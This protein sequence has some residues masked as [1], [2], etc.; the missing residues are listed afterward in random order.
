MQAYWIRPRDGGLVAFAALVETYAEPGGSEMD[1][2]AIVTASANADIAHIHERMPVVI[3]PRDFSRWLDCRTQE[4]RHVADLMRPAGPGL[5]EAVPVSGLVN[6]V[7]NTGPE[8]QEMALPEGPK[9]Q[10]PKRR[11]SGPDDAQMTLL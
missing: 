10:E 3:D 1:T 2:C 5:F 7:A 4:P 8:I 6:K 9:P 11:K